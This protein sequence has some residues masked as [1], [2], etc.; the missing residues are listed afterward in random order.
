M[1]HFAWIRALSFSA[2]VTVGFIVFAS[3]C[4]D[5]SG[6]RTDVR[7]GSGAPPT[8][9]DNGSNENDKSDGATTG[10]PEV[11][12]LRAFAEVMRLERSVSFMISPPATNRPAQTSC[13]NFL[14][15]PLPGGMLRIKYQCHWA[16]PNTDGLKTIAWDLTN[17]EDFSKN[18]AGT[19]FGSASLSMRAAHADTPKNLLL[20]GY[21]TRKFQVDNFSPIGDIAHRPFVVYSSS[22][23]GQALN[24]T[25]QFWISGI[26]GSFRKPAA[27]L[28]LEKDAQISMTFWTK[29]KS[30]STANPVK[31]TLLLT[32]L[33]DISFSEGAC[34]RPLGKFSWILVSGDSTTS[35]RSG[36]LTADAT[37]LTDLD[38]TK[39]D[40][41]GSSCLDFN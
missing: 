8:G 37:E 18:A 20:D 30:A 31:K 25:T 7:V 28:I 26:R 22:A 24:P 33:E 40:W 21:Y 12:K 11:Y 16:E 39:T 41:P 2:T 29:L 5:M 10:S 36:I 3:G 27:R 35:E 23:L 15:S 32:A 38:G 4:G 9:N 1:K 6:Q 19:A 34:P 13:L 17:F 14:A